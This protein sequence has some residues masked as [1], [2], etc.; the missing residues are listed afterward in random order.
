M[1][2]TGAGSRT[3]FSKN[4]AFALMAGNKRRESWWSAPQGRHLE[5]LHGSLQ[6][7]P[8]LTVVK[9]FPQVVAIRQVCKGTV[10]GFLP[11]AHPRFNRAKQLRRR[12]KQ[13]SIEQLTALAT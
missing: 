12:G 7:L 6:F 5:G 4:P 3:S 8:G 2:F 10:E 9:S 13:S 11:A 1:S